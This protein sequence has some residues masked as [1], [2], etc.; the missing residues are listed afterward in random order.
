MPS[1]PAGAKKWHGL[2]G[3][4]RLEGKIG[5]TRPTAKWG[6]RARCWAKSRILIGGASGDTLD[7]GKDDDLLIGGTTAYDADPMALAALLTE[8]ASADYFD[9]IGHL[10]NGG[11][12]N[13][14]FVLNASTVFRDG[15]TDLMLGGSGRDWFLSFD[16]AGVD[17]TD[18]VTHGNKK[19]FLD[20]IS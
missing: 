2:P 17:L 11:G 15:V 6:K 16:A 5:K 9:R 20:G 12:L 18:L 14:S 8:W 4:E 19:E 13:G 3:R 7:G 1:L 10:W